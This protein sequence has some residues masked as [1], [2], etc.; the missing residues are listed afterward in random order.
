M[1]RTCM[2]CFLLQISQTLRNKTLEKRD[3]INDA[4]GENKCAS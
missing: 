4:N 2:F 1:D 3:W